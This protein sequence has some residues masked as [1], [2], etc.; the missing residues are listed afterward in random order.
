M[1]YSV[2]IY[3]VRE[4]KKMKVG[5]EKKG[6]EKKL[7]KRQLALLVLVYRFRFVTIA[8]IMTYEGQKHHESVRRRLDE[9]VNRGFLFK[10]A[11]KTY[12][13]DRRPAEY[14]LTPAAISVLRNIPGTSEREFKRLYARKDVSE[15]FIACSL[16]LFD[17]RNQF[18]RLYGDR[19]SF[20]TKPQLKVDTFDYL[21]YPLPEAFIT[22]EA[23]TDRERHFFVEYFDDSLSIGLHGRKIARYM[24][25]EQEGEWNV[26]ELSFPV[27]LIVCQSKRMLMKAKKRVCYLERQSES[28]IRFY[29]VDLD[30]LIRQR[31]V[32]QPMW[33]NP[34]QNEFETL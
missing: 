11:D 1:I 27:V 22:L 26:T 8:Q 33:L 13:I 19:L 30:T 15:R 4:E 7:L 6:E 23:D 28:G 21:P 20:V 3:I 9:L 24:S 29:L 18:A 16:A 5:E 25:Y 10:R 12:V 31:D 14:S 17:I 34:I 2:Y 32:R